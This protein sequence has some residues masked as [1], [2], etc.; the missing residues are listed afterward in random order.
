MFPFAEISLAIL[1]QIPRA[2]FD[3]GNFFVF[4]LAALIVF[5]QYRR[6]AETERRL[7][8]VVKNDPGRQMVRAILEGL[9]GGLMGSFVLVFIGVSLSNAGINYVVVIAL[10]LMIIS[11][12]LVCFSYAG[13]I[14][15]IFSLLVG[16]PKIDIPGLM[17]LV[18]VLHITESLLIRLF[19]TGAATPV[20]ARRRQGDLV[21]GYMLQR[22]WPIPI[23]ILLLVFL[24]RPAPTGL[25]SMPDWWPLIRPMGQVADNPNFIYTLLPVVAILGYGDLAVTSTPAARTRKTSG[26]LM[27]YSVALLAISIV[28]SRLPALV[29]LA[30]FFAPFGHEL[31]V[32]W[33]SRQEQEGAPVL[34]TQ[35]G[36]GAGVL[37]V[38]P[39][40]P[41]ARA[42]LR[43]GDVVV[44]LGG[45]TVTGRDD[46]FQA[47]ETLAGGDPARLR[48]MAIT[49]RRGGSAGGR[50]EGAAAMGGGNLHEFRAPSQW[51][52][53]KMF[54]LILMPD[55]NDSE[56]IEMRPRDRWARVF[57][58]LKRTFRF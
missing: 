48:G 16:W 30:A 50:G 6:V 13:G 37:D 11:P 12:R 31:V 8:G 58:W 14:V 38:V 1:R 34:V 32:R 10:L 28:A 52:P 4:W 27:L 17:G 25:I 18:A 21:G 42:G 2:L 35:P 5:W 39:G 7:F 36:A 43:A 29:W 24:Q 56:H 15:S 54:G 55:E 23:V 47:L 51:D 9:V 40:S 19:G 46:L 49:V 3:P 57:D 45:A 41:A 26:A 20:Y 44:D 53:G 22:F 33:G